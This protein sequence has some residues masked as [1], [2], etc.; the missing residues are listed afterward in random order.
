MAKQTLR[1]AAELII[2]SID[3]FMASV[4]YSQSWA[5]SAAMQPGH[6][7]YSKVYRPVFKSSNCPVCVQVDNHADNI[8]P[9]ALHYLACLT[10]RRRSFERARSVYL[11]PG[12]GTCTDA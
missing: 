11:G 9:A 12:H 10:C 1:A 3:V 7:G 4:S 5:A 6:R 2:S 8:D